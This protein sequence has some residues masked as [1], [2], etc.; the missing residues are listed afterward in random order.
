[1]LTEINGTTSAKLKRFDGYWGEKAKIES[2]LAEYVPNGFAR[3]AALRTGE[4][5]V[6]EAV[7][8]SQ[9]ANMDQSQ[10]H[11]VAMPRTNTLYLN[12]KSPIFND[13]EMRKIA[14]Q[15]VD[16]KQIINTVYENHADFANGLLGPALAWA[17]PIRVELGRLP[18]P[19]GLKANGEKIVLGTY[20]DRAE[21]PEVATL[22]KQQLEAAGFAVELDIREYMQIENDALSGKFDAF[23]LSR[24][25]VLDS[26]DPVAYMQSDFGCK[27]SFNLGLFCSEEVDQALAYA[28]L[29][30]LGELRQKAIIDAERK[31]LGQ[32]AAIPLLHAR[33]IQGE[34]PAV[35]N[36]KRDPR[37][38]R[39]VDQFTEVN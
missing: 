9:I 6:V 28:D 24:A 4:A 36:V 26:G 11:E 39:L 20:S 25:T 8:V 13:I 1:V 16:R 17:D 33:V 38:R 5:D 37:E 14:T 35:K 7:P 10:L 19:K 23:L 22:L 21:L 27:G 31:I 12:N 34:G 32:Y 18:T 29:Q 15:A 2:I 3:A 30:P